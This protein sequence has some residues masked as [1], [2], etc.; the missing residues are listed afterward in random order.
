MASPDG[1]DVHETT[2]SGEWTEESVLRLGREAGEELKAGAVMLCHEIPW[3]HTCIWFS[4]SRPVRRAVTYPVGACSRCQQRR[5]LQTTVTRSHTAV[6]VAL[7][8]QFCDCWCL[9]RCAGD[10][11]PRLL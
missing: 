5:L 1:R 9:V 6:Q 11:R 7:R 2:R 3:Q 10:G 8:R 4:D